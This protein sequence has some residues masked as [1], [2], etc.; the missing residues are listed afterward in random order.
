MG[1]LQSFS[2][3][4]EKTEHEGIYRIKGLRDVLVNGGID[5]AHPFIHGLLF[6]GFRCSFPIAFDNSIGMMSETSDWKIDVYTNDGGIILRGSNTFGYPRT[7]LS[8]G[9]EAVNLV[10]EIT[11]TKLSK[12]IQRKLV[13]HMEKDA[14]NKSEEEWKQSILRFKSRKD[15]TEYYSGKFNSKLIPTFFR[16]RIL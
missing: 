14:E 7:A 6:Y 11:R 5:H 2:K 12:H 1:D 4:F 15:V 10:A 13:V 8:V 3:T 9:D 16:K